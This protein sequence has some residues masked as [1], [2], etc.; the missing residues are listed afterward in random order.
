MNS[1]AAPS[2]EAHHRSHGPDTGSKQ[3]QRKSDKNAQIKKKERERERN[4]ED[5]LTKKRMKE[6]KKE[7]CRYPSIG[8]RWNGN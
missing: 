8:H 7:D 3:F 2:L 1:R 6:R 5:K 4:K